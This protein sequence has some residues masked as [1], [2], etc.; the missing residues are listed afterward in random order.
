MSGLTIRSASSADLQDICV[1]EGNSFSSPYPRFLV[2]TLLRECGDS[3]LVASHPNGNIVG[4]C[5]ACVEGE[6]AHLISI[7]VRKDNHRKRV[8]SS[9]IRTLIERLINAGL[10]SVKLEVKPGNEGA[11]AFYKQLGFEEV[12]LVGNY[13]EDGS[14]ALKMCMNLFNRAA[15]RKDDR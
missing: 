13:Y 15:D 4:Y 7:A 3:F 8:G 14:P 2:D 11:I 5:I 12:T 6:S 10:K 1:I 9:L